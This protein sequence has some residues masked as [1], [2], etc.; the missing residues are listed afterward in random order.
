MQRRHTN[1]VELEDVGL[2]AHLAEEALSG[3]AVGAVGLGEDSY[4]WSSVS[5]VSL[6][7][8]SMGGGIHSPTA[9]LSMISCA[10]VLAAMI[11]FGLAE[12]APLKKLRMKLMVG[13]S[14]VDECG[15][16]GMQAIMS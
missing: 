9:L 16:R 1:L 4:R 2:C 5:D 14:G 3:L 10:L 7:M 12:R 15:G 13:E 6:R 8:P 11:V